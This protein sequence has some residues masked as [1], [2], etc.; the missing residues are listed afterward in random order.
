MKQLEKEADGETSFNI[1]PYITHCTLDIIAESA[2]GIQV[3]AMSQ[4]EN[5]YVEALY[6]LCRE[7]NSRITKGWLRDDFIFFKT[8]YGKRFLKYLAVLHGTT[9]EVINERKRLLRKSNGS[10]GKA[11]EDEFGA[12]KR[13][14]FLDLLLE[15]SK[16]GTV[17]T[18]EQIREEVDTFMFEGHDTTTASIAWTIFLLGIHQDIQVNN[19]VEFTVKKLLICFRSKHLKKSMRSFP[20]ISNL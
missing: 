2:M 19:F 3:N 17:L 5:S 6:G 18:H 9:N 15:V 1:F 16:D 4:K 10:D 7:A 11:T 13:K 8:E 20:V 12:K 14:A